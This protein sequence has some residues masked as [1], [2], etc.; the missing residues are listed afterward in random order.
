MRTSITTGN[1]A[2]TSPNISGR[3]IS[4]GY[5]LIQNIS[6]VTF[7]PNK[8][9]FTDVS[10][11]PHADLRINPALSGRSPQKYALHADSPAIDKIPLLYC[12]VR[13]IFNDQSRLCTDQRGMKRSHGQGGNETLCDIGAYKST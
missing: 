9:H 7:D 2:N 3:L 6:G 11:E 1:H 8:Q 4:D 10:V 13:D 5:N 12:Q